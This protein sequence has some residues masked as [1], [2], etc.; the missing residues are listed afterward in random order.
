MFKEKILAELVKK[1]PGLSKQFLGLVAVQMATKV[2]EEGG[3]EAAVAEL[4][5]APISIETLAAEFQ[6]EG[7]RRVT[8]AMK[9]KP[10]KTEEKPKPE[11]PPAPAEEIPAWAKKMEETNRALAEKLA[12]LESEKTKG[13]IKQKAADA[14]KDVPAWFWEEWALP[15]KEE[16]LESF[17]TK[18]KTKYE[19]VT[20]D[21]NNKGLANMITPKGG[22]GGGDK[23]ASKEEVASIVDNIT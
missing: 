19:T 10:P 5:N 7:D 15:E 12:A 22:N 9:P 21:S 16:D 11:N 2:T 1:Y 6:K 4:D 17:V 13:T 18:A 3:I 14:L 23:K 8:E 20:Q